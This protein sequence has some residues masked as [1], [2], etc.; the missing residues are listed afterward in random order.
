M[1]TEHPDNGNSTK[2][3][4]SLRDYVD[5]LYK[6]Q[7]D[8]RLALKELLCVK[9]D[10]L[11]K[12]TSLAKINMDLR[13]ENTN[14]WRQAMMD[15]EALFSRKDDEHRLDVRINLLELSKASLE[16]K[17]SQMSVNIA[18]LLAVVGWVVA[19]VLKFVK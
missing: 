7:E 17:A 9:I 1:P 2:S 18:Y 11:E 19:L 3:L 10:A 8:D 12:A 5:L 14:E 4:V 16:G 15:R 13:M 6:E